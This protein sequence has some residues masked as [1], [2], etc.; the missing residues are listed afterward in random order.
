MQAKTADGMTIIRTAMPNVVCMGEGEKIWVDVRVK[1][2][3][4]R[5]KD[6]TADLSPMRPIFGI[7]NSEIP[8]NIYILHMLIMFTYFYVN[9]YICCVFAICLGKHQMLVLYCKGN[10][11]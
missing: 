9:F 1:R 6:D 8:L 10:M 2:R 5:A 11:R 7:W 4:R 3:I